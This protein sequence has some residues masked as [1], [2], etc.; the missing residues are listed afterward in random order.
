MEFKH[1]SVM[2]NECIDGLMVKKD[3]VYFDGTLG[4]G[5][6]SQAILEK[7]GDNGFL[8]ATDLDSEALSYATEKLKKYKNFK[9]IKS[10]FKNFL[11][12]C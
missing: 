10:N 7:L 2:L 9:A 6:H 3:G 5:G 12:I 4:G 11:K 8:F 1:V